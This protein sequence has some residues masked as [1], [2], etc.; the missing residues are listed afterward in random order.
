MAPEWDSRTATGSTKSAARPYADDRL[1]AGSGGGTLVTGPDRATRNVADEGCDGL[2]G[3]CH[4]GPR[5][6]QRARLPL[7]PGEEVGARLVGVRALARTKEGRVCQRAIAYVQ[8]RRLADP[9]AERVFLTLAERTAPSDLDD[10]DSPMGLLLSDT[11]IPRLAAGLGIDADRFRS[12]LREVRDLVP[13]DVLEHSDGTWEIVYGPPYT[14][15]PEPLQLRPAEDGDDIGPVNP[16]TMPGWESYST[17]GL[18]KPLGLTDQG[19]LYAQL[20]RNTDD[21]GAA[22]RIWITPPGYAPT[23]LDQLAQAIATEITPYEPV[24]L[25]PSA[26]RIWLVQV[27]APPPRTPPQFS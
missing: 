24:P 9:L 10:D 3:V 7:R 16:F 20:Y 23:T 27:T 25:P 8:G 5:E 12:L 14:S 18:D 13:M 11:D 17:W 4:A 15:P 21:P 19:Y 2:V 26:I 22:P 1:P 6:C